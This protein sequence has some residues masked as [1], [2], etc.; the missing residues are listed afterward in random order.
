MDGNPPSAVGQPEQGIAEHLRRIAQAPTRPERARAIDEFVAMLVRTDFVYP[1]LARLIGEDRHAQRLAL[2]SFLRLPLPIDASICD[3]M[4]SL[5]NDSHFPAALRLGVAV[6]CLRSS[7]KN[8]AFT[9]SV[10]D[11]LT[12][13]VHPQRAL[14][15]LRSLKRRV[16]EH[17][18]LQSR[19][20]EL[21]ANS[22]IACPSC[23]MRLQRSE[24]V[25]HLWQAHRL[26]MEGNLARDPWKLIEQWLSEYARTDDKGLLERSCELGQQLDPVA[27]LTRVH[28]LLLRAGLTDDEAK[29]N[30]TAQAK[31]RRASL[32]PHCYALT[33]P[34]FEPLPSPIPVSR[35]QFDDHGYSVEVG[36]RTIVSRI[37]AASPHRV[38]YNG[39]E[40]GHGLTLRGVVILVILPLVLMAFALSIYLPLDVLPP[41]TPVSILLLAALLLFIRKRMAERSAGD[42]S[43]RAIEGAWRHFAP[44]LHQP[45]FSEN[46][47]EFLARLAVT[48]VGSGDPDQRANTLERVS[49]L[50]TME[51]GHGRTASGNLAALRRLEIDDI[52]RGDQDPL[53]IIVNDLAA[54]LANELPLAYGEQL[55]EAWPD[56][57]RDA[58]WRARLRVLICS[59][60]FELGFEP[61]SLHELG[62]ASPILGAAFASE[63]LIGLCRL[64]WLWDV[65]P[66]R[67]WQKNGAASPVFDLASFPALGGQYLAARP[68]LLLF[69]PFSVG[70]DPE[71]ADPIL[72]C[73]E[74]VV[75]RDLVIK[76]PA[77]AISIKGRSF[78]SGW[79]L[80]VGRQKL[81]FRAEPTLLARR[82][83][84]WTRF[85]FQELRP[86]AEALKNRRS[87]DKIAPLMKQKTLLCPECGSPF[88]A[89]RGEVGLLADG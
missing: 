60:A 64:R 22:A 45:E 12:T 24:L 56:F 44:E 9:Q 17:S 28:R 36:N 3:L 68:D 15:R 26:L 42:P 10:L 20:A 50:T 52:L 70:D 35:G 67:V 66:S 39:P 53:P 85:V 72:I 59:R 43:T 80:L 62:R 74:G 58:G 4:L 47:A 61:R 41:L 79:D 49:R 54:C 6:Q 1:F 32:C 63:D 57:A 77:A 18:G 87:P 7:T 86:A 13:D 8:Q 37:F 81:S 38:L 88:L 14:E 25:V 40:P 48:S 23:G 71:A 82:L 34:P 5:L 16:P 21:E 78:P 31:G 65:R 51:L 75:Y 76:D 89:L 69:Q 2:E 29:E 55:L 33:P 30:L 19:I 83:K 84:G 73:E 46:D 11:V 27:G